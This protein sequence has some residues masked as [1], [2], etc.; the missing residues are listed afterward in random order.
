MLWN[1]LPGHPERYFFRSGSVHVSS[2]FLIRVFKMVRIWSGILNMVPDQHTDEFFRMTVVG[3][4]DRSG[5]ALS[6]RYICDCSY[7]SLYQIF[8]DWPVF[9]RQAIRSSQHNWFRIV[10][11]KTCSPINCPADAYGV[12]YVF[13]S[14]YNIML[15]GVKT[16][17]NNFNISCGRN[18]HFDRDQLLNKKQN[19][20]QNL[21]HKRHII[22]N[23]LNV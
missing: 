17:L 19:N 2:G 11:R 20:N 10:P 12:V 5:T 22:Y 1:L 23:T 4:Y 6:F 14:Q 13:S 16:L 9:R 15:K 3:C 7:G 21:S 18:V 8:C